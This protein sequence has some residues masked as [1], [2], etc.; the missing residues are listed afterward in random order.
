[1]Y[2][3]LG[4]HEIGYRRK[5]TNGAAIL[6]AYLPQL[7][8]A[9]EMGVTEEIYRKMK[10]QLFQENFKVILEPLIRSGQQ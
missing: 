7:D 8:H 1:M 10:K 3:Y 5:P 2:L 9:K 6:L 4:N